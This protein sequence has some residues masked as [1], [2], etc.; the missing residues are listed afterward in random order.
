MKH[1]YID[2]IFHWLLR[3]WLKVF[4]I[5]AVLLPCILFYFNDRS[6]AEYED[7]SFKQS[8]KVYN[9][10]RNMIG[11][12]DIPKSSGVFDVAKSDG[13]DLRVV[14]TIADF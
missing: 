14:S 13:S 4:V 5:L 9:H 10:K 8:F 1:E 11:F 12:I 3:E 6:E 2:A 7:W